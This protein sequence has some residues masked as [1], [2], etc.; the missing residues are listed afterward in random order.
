MSVVVRYKPVGMSTA[1]YDETVRRFQEEVGDPGLDGFELHVC[2][3]S[4]GDLRVSEI[5]ASREQWQAY[6][7]KLYPILDA[8]GIE[9]GG[10]PD[11]FEVHNL[12][13]R[14]DAAA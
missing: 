9:R 14:E 11:V 12:M 3:G 13:R 1:Q 10:E 4:D 6:T 7:E 5:W 2:F 8:V